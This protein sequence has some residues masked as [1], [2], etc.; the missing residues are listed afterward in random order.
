MHAAAVLPEY[1]L[2]HKGGIHAMLPC[3]LLNDYPQ[4]H[5]LVGHFQPFVVAHI[6]FML[7]RGHFMVTVFYLHPHVLKGKDRLS[8][9]VTAHIQRPS[10]K[11]A[12]PVNDL[13]GLVTLE[14]EV[15]KLWPNIIGIPLFR[16]LFQHPFQHIP[17]IS[18]VM[19]SVRLQD[20]A[21]HPGHRFIAGSPW[22]ELK[23][24][25]VRFGN[26]IAFFN[27]GKAF[28]GRA[29]KA[30]ALGQPLLQFRRR[31]GKTL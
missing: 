15:L 31:D 12:S 4:G 1:R 30:H 13:G 26:H 24:G 17:R 11:I 23:G 3:N 22:Q 21:K 29:I 20:I 2:R 19:A 6:N 18:L 14:V 9:Q 25:R 27:S 8:S 16:R 7:A 5:G 28:N 10:V